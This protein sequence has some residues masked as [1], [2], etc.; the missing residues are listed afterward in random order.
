[1]PCDRRH[2]CFDCP[3]LKEYTDKHGPLLTNVF[4]CPIAMQGKPTDT[5]KAEAV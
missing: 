5:P 4:Y 2:S 3:E 1:M